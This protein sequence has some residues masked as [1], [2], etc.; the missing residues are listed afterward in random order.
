MILTCPDCE[1]SY[2]VADERIPPE[3]R[4]V[5]CTSCG[6]RWLATLERPPEPPA[7]DPPVEAPEVA[8]VEPEP[9]VGPD[10]PEESPREAPGDALPRKFRAKAVE[11][12]RMRE[13]AATGAIWAGM[14]AVMAVMIAVTVVF[15]VDVVK[16]WPGAAAAYA[17]VGLPVNSLGLALEGIEAEP[18]LQDGH[19]ALSV[20][21]MI[22]NIENHPITA[23]PLRI[24]LINGSGKVV[25]AKVARA[26]DPRI[27]PGETRHFALAFLD[28]PSTARELEVAF[29]V[30]HAPTHKAPT[31]KAAPAPEPQG[32]ALRG[33]AE[34]HAPPPP[35]PVEAQ[36]LQAEDAHAGGHD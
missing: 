34:A 24:T 3:G 19:A 10:A 36:P 7:E 15:R 11:T 33:P 2:Y 12:R 22:R 9:E 28:P 30:D 6:H 21:G 8:A 17:S 14:A 23:P 26:T 13:A 27:P 16:V 32:L 18:A 31:P 29:D 1:T 4:T 25:A 5:K 20:S 35:A